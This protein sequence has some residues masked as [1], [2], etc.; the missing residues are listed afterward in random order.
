MRVSSSVS[1]AREAVSGFADMGVVGAGQQASV[2]SSTVAGMKRGV[3][4]ANSVASDVSELVS[5][6]SAEADRV[7]ALASEIEARDVDDA[8]VLGAGL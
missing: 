3:T 2:G 1:A 7:V 4:F 8:L 5:A 6:V